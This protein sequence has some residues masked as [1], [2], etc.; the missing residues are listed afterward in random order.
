MIV[1][2]YQL[3]TV[4]RTLVCERKN[5]LSEAVKELGRIHRCKNSMLKSIAFIFPR[6]IH[7]KI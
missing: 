2:T 7:K 4:S 3:W 6:L 1:L 5:K